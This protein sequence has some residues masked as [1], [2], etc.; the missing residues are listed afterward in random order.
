[1]Q[2]VFKYAIINLI[3]NS[4]T[5]NAQAGNHN[6]LFRFFMPDNYSI[7]PTAKTSDELKFEKLLNERKVAREFQER[8]HLDWNDNYELYRNKVKTN[9]LTQRQAVNIPLM[10]ETVKTLLSR[11]DDPPNVDWKEMGGDEM[12]ELVYQE[13]WNDQFKRK[14]FEWI[15]IVDKKN[16]LLYGLS[17]KKLNI[18][19]GIDVSVLDPFDVVFDP[20]M[21]PIDIESARFI[22]HQNIFRSLR[23]ILAD[24]RYDEKGKEKLKQWA[25]SRDAIIQSQYNK[26]ELE[27]KQERLK[28]MGVDSEEFD[29][30]SGGDVIVNLCEHYTKGWNTKKKEF[31]KRVI[32]YAQDEYELLDETLMSLIGVDFWPFVVWSEDIESN[33]I[34]PDGIADLVRTPNKILNIW[35][36]QQAENRT[37]QNFQMHWYDA[38]IQGYQPQTYEP[39]PGRMLPAPGDP[40]KTIM[41]V[42]VNGLDE[43]FTAIDFLIRI[44][45][46]GSGATA[47]EKGVSEK[48]QI[49]LGEVQMLVGKAA[50]RTIGMTKFYRGAWYE[51]ALKWDKLMQEN[52]PKMLNLFK[53]NSRGKIYPRRVYPIDW[54][55]EAGYEPMLSSTS[56]QEEETM[57][58][59]QKWQFILGMFPNNLSLRKIAAKRSLEI[60]DLTPQELQE[61]Q[62]AE[63][64]AQQMMQ[65]SAQPQ[66]QGVNPELVNSIQSGLG[67]LQNLTSRQ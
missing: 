33:D 62:Q 18:G 8:R 9:R 21:N 55:S 7:Q 35:F 60:V 14:K 13:I 59:V 47:I 36:S 27:K 3:T 56:E 52:A 5:L 66:P 63:E 41:P 37:L 39:G 34:Y 46:R 24:E 57:K 43:T 23:D 30:F 61:V 4:S 12:K 2:C 40:N 49:T 48:K 19:E 64:Q 38:T 15:D 28:A 53:T 29:K 67:E 54:R 22:I 45:E 26:E 10:K 51:L 25:L 65:Q 17:T 58:G 11:I 6:K 50:E 1:M 32:V 31:E 16:V 20:I 44:V 42:Q